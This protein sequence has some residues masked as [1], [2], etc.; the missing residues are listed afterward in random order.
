MC[1]KLQ[2]KISMTILID[3]MFDPVCWVRQ[4]SVHLGWFVRQARLSTTQL[5]PGIHALAGRPNFSSITEGTFLLHSSS[6]SRNPRFRVQ[7]FK[8]SGLFSG[9]ITQNPRTQGFWRC[10]LTYRCLLKMTT[11]GLA[12]NKTIFSCLSLLGIIRPVQRWSKRTFFS[13]P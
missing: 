4:S 9:Q 11:G 6:E 3:F 8:C 10:L 5:P 1:L 13:C 7:G 2:I 12:P